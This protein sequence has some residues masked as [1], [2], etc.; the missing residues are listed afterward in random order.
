MRLQIYESGAIFCQSTGDNL[1]A[2]FIF[3]AA[4]IDEKLCNCFDLKPF[5]KYLY[6]TQIE[7]AGLAAAPW[8]TEKVH[9]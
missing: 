7:T 2:M 4:L 8:L 1:P 9:F 6:D 3:F 5:L